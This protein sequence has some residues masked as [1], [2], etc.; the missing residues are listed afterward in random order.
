[1]INRLIR[2]WAAYYNQGPV[3]QVYRAIQWNTER[4]LQCWLRRRTGQLWAVRPSA[5][6]G[7]LSLSAD[8]RQ[9]G[10]VTTGRAPMTRGGRLFLYRLETRLKTFRNL[11]KLTLLV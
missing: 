3:V 8:A 1:M 2:G 5:P 4:R 11:L 7:K 6:A 10:T 9:T